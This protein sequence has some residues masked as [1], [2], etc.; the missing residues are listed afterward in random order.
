MIGYNPVSNAEYSWAA[1]GNYSFCPCHLLMILLSYY[2]HFQGQ[3]LLFK[4][5]DFWC[6]RK[7]ED[8]RFETLPATVVLPKSLGKQVSSFRTE[9]SLRVDR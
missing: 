2:S 3:M 5:S 7:V 8:W 9:M 1:A 6:S 4:M